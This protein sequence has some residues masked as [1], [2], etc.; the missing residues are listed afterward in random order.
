[1]KFHKENTNSTVY[2]D[3]NGLFIIDW[4]PD[5]KLEVED[6]KLIVDIFAEWSNGEYWKVL[7][8]FP[9]GA[10]ASGEARN[11]GAN[12]EKKSS[13]EAFVFQNTLHR[14]LF[15]LYQRFRAQLY[16]IRAFSNLNDAKEWLIEVEVS[17]NVEK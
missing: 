11:Y 1:M 15:K 16:P 2:V 17:A 7:H 8:V 4:K 5:N 12:R 6:F 14:S 13:A 3:E 9:K 10:S